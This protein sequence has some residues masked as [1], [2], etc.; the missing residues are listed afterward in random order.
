MT[1]NSILAFLSIVLLAA[2]GG[3]GGGSSPAPTPTPAPTPAPTPSPYSYY[4]IM[5]E[6]PNGHVW[7]SFALATDIEWYQPGTINGVYS[8]TWLKQYCWAGYNTSNPL[9]TTVTE[10]TNEFRIQLQGTDNDCYDISYNINLNAF[11]TD[12]IELYLPGESE[13][14]YALI[15]GYFADI[16]VTYFGALNLPER[17]IEYIDGN[18][19]IIYKNNSPEELHVPLVLGDYTEIGD[20]P[21]TTTNKTLETIAFYHEANYLPDSTYSANIAWT[22]VSSLTFN[23]S[24]GTFEGT[25]ELNTAMD[26]DSFLAGLGPQNVF[27]TVPV[28]TLDITGTISGNRF[29]GDIQWS[30]GTD[31][32]VGY[33]DGGFFGPDGSEVGASVVFAD[34]DGEFADDLAFGTAL[35]IGE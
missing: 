7:D 30:D 13:P 9:E 15:N 20:M 27:T 22:G 33:I 21:S 14:S 4:K 26:L 23:H 19:G 34:N 31:S 11:N 25:M 35:M 5:D 8:S 1:K 6:V 10:Y 18:M 3:G 16:S 28:V 12:V 32:A 24:S 17:G 29:Y 2:C